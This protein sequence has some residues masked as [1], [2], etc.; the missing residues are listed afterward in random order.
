MKNHFLSRLVKVGRVLAFSS[1]T[2]V[3]EMGAHEQDDE[4]IAMSFYGPDRCGLTGIHTQYFPEINFRLYPG[5]IRIP[6]DFLTFD[7]STEYVYANS[8]FA[9]APQKQTR[10]K[11]RI[12]ALATVNLTY[13]ICLEQAS[14]LNTRGFLSDQRFSRLNDLDL[15]IKPH[16]STCSANAYYQRTGYQGGQGILNFCSSNY[17]T[18]RLFDVVA[19]EA[20]HAM[21]DALNPALYGAGE[22]HPHTAIHEAFADWG[23]IHASLSLADREERTQAIQNFLYSSDL[24]IA[25]GW[26]GSPRCL[27]SPN[28]PTPRERNSCEGHDRSMNLTSLMVT[29]MRETYQEIAYDRELSQLLRKNCV[30]GRESMPTVDYFDR[31]LMGTV[32]KSSQFNSLLDFSEHLLNT[33]DEFGQFMNG[34]N[35]EFYD[36]VQEKI[37]SEIENRYDILNRCAAN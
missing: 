28:N 31:L 5:D 1:F 32:V 3:G 16:D 11:E 8:C 4:R 22:N 36:T 33:N 20:N 7:S 17:P 10:I 35:Q 37:N 13:D 6:Y 15:V 2:L 30:S 18:V 9:L 12:S 14:I 27:R 25:K 24:C 34:T 19:H 29:S 23:A 26:N 21:L